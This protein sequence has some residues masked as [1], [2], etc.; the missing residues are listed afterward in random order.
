MIERLAE[1]DLE[2]RFGTFH[3][4]L[5]GDGDVE[6]IA[7]VVGDLAGQENVICRIHSACIGGHVFNSVEC[8]CAAEMSAAQEHTQ[9]SGKG[10]IIY[11]DQE[12]KGNGHLGLLKSIPFKKAGRSQSEAY[13]LAG[14]SA[15]ARDYRPAAEIL[16][17]LKVGSIVLLTDNPDKAESLR[18]H[19]VNVAEM[20]PLSI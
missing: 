5:Y 2:T 15:D 17:D 19:G 18:R 6:S 13:V 11:L 4:V 1:R 12:G 14:F 3:E 20:Q 7:L 9:R 16:A 8:A 10:V